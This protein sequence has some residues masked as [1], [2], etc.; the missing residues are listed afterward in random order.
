MGNSH[1]KEPK[2]GD[3]H[4]HPQSKEQQ[5]PE[6]KPDTT[7]KPIRDSYETIEQV[8]QGLREAGLESSNLIIGIDYTIS[9][10]TAGKQTFGGKSLHHLSSDL[11]N[12]YQQVISI[13]GQTLEVFDDDKLI[14]VYGFGDKST[15]DQ[16][17]FPFFPDKISFGFQQVLQRYN[18]VTPNIQLAGPT[19][20]APVIREAIRIVKQAKAYHILV[21]IAD[22]QVTNDS[23]YCKAESETRAAIVEASNYPLSIILV[24]VGDGPWD[25]MDEFDDALPTRK[26]DNF[27]FVNFAKVMSHGQSNQEK[28][29]NF[30]LA[31]L[32]EIPEQ[33]QSIRNLGYLGS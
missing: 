23:E 20:F 12:P 15:H 32:Q 22:G 31:A 1:K 13:V 27:Q 19:S 11:F 8:Q 24:G 16:T 2:G 3:H 26:F 25:L 33:F 28:E 29:V 4:P 18:E 7:F 10:T 17:V 6:K 9:N 5:Q 14:P 21:I 30:A